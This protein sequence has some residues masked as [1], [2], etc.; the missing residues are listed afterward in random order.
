MAF[1]SHPDF[2]L[3]GFGAAQRVHG[4]AVTADM[5]KLL[6]QQPLLGRNFSRE[7]DRPHAAKVLLLSYNLWHRLFGGSPQAVGRML[8]L[9]GESY[10]V[11]GVLPRGRF[12]PIAPIYGFHWE[13]TLILAKVG[14][15]TAL[16]G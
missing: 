12:S 8:K 1:F 6:G 13:P 15:S 16:A 3:S 14:I 5:L 4:A 9:S 2:N 10:T 7:E 11:I